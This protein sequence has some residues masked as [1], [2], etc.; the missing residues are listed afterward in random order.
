MTQ[1]RKKPV[2]VE[3]TQWF[4]PGDHPEVLVGIHTFDEGFR[5]CAGC[6]RLIYD[7]GVIGTLEGRMSVCPGDWIITGVAGEHYPCK[8][9]IFEAIYESVEKGVPGPEEQRLAAR[10][11]YVLA[12]KL[13]RART[14]A[15]L[16]EAVHALK[17]YRDGVKVPDP[18]GSEL[19]AS[20][21]AAAF[22]VLRALLGNWSAM[23]CEDIDA[24]DWW[25][26][27]VD[28]GLIA[29][30]WRDAPCGDPCGCAEVGAHKGEKVECYVETPLFHAILNEPLTRA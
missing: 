24:N 19:H 17:P 8:P 4:S 13:H 3:A 23:I 25:E 16:A 12:V 7:H 6:K 27:L 10:S 18:D 9:E 2:V 11:D 22:R 14:G 29:P 5:V 21:R 20:Q 28:A 26:A 15:S 30:E 1:Y